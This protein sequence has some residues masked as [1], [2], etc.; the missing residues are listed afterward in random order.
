MNTLIDLVITREVKSS[1][2]GITG[3]ASSDGKRLLPIPE[4]ALTE[5]E[6]LE[7]L[8]ALKAKEQ[9]AEDGKAFAYSYT[10]NKDMAD[11]SRRVS[12]AYEM[13]SKED[14]SEETRVL[15][16]SWELFMHTNALNP[17]MYPSLRR[18]ENEIVSMTSWMLNGDENVAGSLTSGGTESI[19]MAIKTYREWAK[20]CRGYLPNPNMVVGQTIHPA[21]EKAAHYFNIE[22]RHVRLTEYYRVDVNAVRAAIDKDTILIVGSAPQYC[23]GVVDPIEE[24]AALAT[25]KGIGMHVDACFGGFM[26]PWMER[27]GCAVPMFDFRV[28]G[29]TSISADVHKYGYASKGASV[30][31]YKTAKLRSYQYFSYANWPGGLFVSPSV[32]A[33]QMM[34]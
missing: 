5:D 24:L 6:V 23:H 8:S 34:L 31:L 28:K 13:Y 2:P 27:L 7:V 3:S 22:I 19:L 4:Y 11:M 33:L 14:N 20:D 26:L 21:F 15:W 18:M 1:L 30:I 12:H 25:E 10:S 32:T 9:K 16:K 29:V 17:T